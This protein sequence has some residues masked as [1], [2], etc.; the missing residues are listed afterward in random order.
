MPTT[1]LTIPIAEAAL[2][3]GLAVVKSLRRDQRYLSAGPAL[4]LRVQFMALGVHLETITMGSGGL[5]LE[6]T[7][8]ERVAAILAGAGIAAWVAHRFLPIYLRMYK[9]AERRTLETLLKKG[10]S[11]NDRQKIASRILAEGGKRLGLLD[12]ERDTRKTLYAIL[13]YAK[14]VGMSQKMAGEL[15]R[16]LVPKGRFVNKGATYRANFIAR[17]EMAHAQRISSIETYKRSKAVKEVIA[18]DGDHDPMCA[19]RNGKRMTF[20]EAEY[21]TGRTHPG[22]VL[23]FGPIV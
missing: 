12:I 18:Y 11:P 6:T 9:N 1:E 23:A 3:P 2:Q 22:C 20:G 4:E 10:F 19:E 17:N 5:L 14:E 7:P 13:S 21:E 16:D 15:I 8:R